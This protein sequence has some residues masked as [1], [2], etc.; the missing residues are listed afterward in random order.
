MNK[1]IVNNCQ[2]DENQQKAVEDNTH[3]ILVIAGAGAGKTLTILGKVKYLKEVLN[4]KDQEILCISYTNETTKELQK[5][6]N[7]RFSKKK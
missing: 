3:N 2:L 5:K 4:Y 7:S 6:F 1:L